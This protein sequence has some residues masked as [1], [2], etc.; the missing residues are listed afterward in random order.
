M[1][2]AY[3]ITILCLLF[4]GSGSANALDDASKLAPVS[5]V[6]AAWFEAR[7]ASFAD[8]AEKVQGSVVNIQTT[9]KISQRQGVSPFPRFGPSDPF[10]NFF[11]KFFEGMPRERTNRSLGSGF[12]VSKDGAI[13]TN[14]HVVSQADEIQVELSDGRKFKAEVV[15]KDERTDIAVIKI[16]GGGDL[17]YASLGDSGKIRPGDWV[18]AI[19][20]PFGLEHTVTVGVVSAMGR[21]L[22]GGPYAK[23]IQTDASINPGNSGG[24]LF[25]LKGEVIGINTM[26]YAGGQGIGFAIP[27]NLA[28]D[29][30]PQLLTKGSVTRGWLGVSIQE[31]TPE[32]AKAFKLKN[33]KGALI[34]DVFTGSPAHDAGFKR[35]DVVVEFN[36]KKVKEPYDLSMLVGRAKRGDKVKVKVLREGKD[37]ELK[38]KIG[39]MDEDKLAAK[40]PSRFGAE[41]G[42][43]DVLGLVVK[44]I[45]PSEATRLDLPADYKGI[46]ITRVEPGSSSERSEVRSGDVLLEVN[47][48]KVETVSE[49]RNVT[50]SIKKGDYVRLLIKRGPASIYL[51]FKVVE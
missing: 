25:N 39:T 41:R 50:S 33:E 17:P 18:M 36:G 37:V 30:M 28:K 20:N 16:K 35:G 12:I 8:L 5:V 10:D 34:A 13:L 14:N 42:K 26:I 22:G 23:F 44:Q 24:P 47:G 7:P 48:K 15:G 45:S 9:K 6:P 3:V 40:E 46:V 11:D 31:I 29:L 19:G 38:V 51:A 4:V 43:A 21:R 49:Y 1:K 27:I 2:K 32:L